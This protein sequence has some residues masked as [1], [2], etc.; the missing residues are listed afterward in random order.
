MLK[1]NSMLQLLLALVMLSIHHVKVSFFW[2]KNDQY[3]QVLQID[4]IVALCNVP[5]SSSK[6]II[7]DKQTSKEKEKEN[8]KQKT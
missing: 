3:I 2:E 7:T 8:R 5:I 1:E 6:Q 4:G